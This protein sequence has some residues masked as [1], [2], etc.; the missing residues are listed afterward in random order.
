MSEIA[1]RSLIRR[2]ETGASELLDAGDV[3][4]AVGQNLSPAELR[5]LEQL[6][7][8]LQPKHEARVEIERLLRNPSQG[9]LPRVL[10]EPLGPGDRAKRGLG[11][12][13]LGGA[14]A[15]FVIGNVPGALG[16]AII[17]AGIGF[18]VFKGAPD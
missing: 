16:G 9:G 12:A 3:R 11:G 14:V 7:R 8:A 6:E 10:K 15:G 4:R 13:V 2:V 1:V 17:G 18:G 5:A